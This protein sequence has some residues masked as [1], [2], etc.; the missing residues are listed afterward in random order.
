MR[1]CVHSATQSITLTGYDPGYDVFMLCASQS[2]THFYQSDRVYFY[3]GKSQTISYTYSKTVST[4]V[5]SWF[6]SVH[7]IQG[8]AD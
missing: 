3:L 6:K 4:N 2:F 1:V 5:N 8:L 7:N